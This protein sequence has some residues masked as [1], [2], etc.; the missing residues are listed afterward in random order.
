M[1]ANFLFWVLLE[2]STSWAQRKVLKGWILVSVGV[3]DN[4]GLP[5]EYM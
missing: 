3:W 1:G 5:G 4:D 2:N